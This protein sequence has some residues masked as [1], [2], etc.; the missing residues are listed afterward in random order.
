MRLALR[1]AL[2]ISSVSYDL[3]EIVGEAEKILKID[4]AIGH[5]IEDRIKTRI[6][7]TLAKVIG[8]EKEVVKIHG[9]A[10]SG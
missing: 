5:D 4:R 10:P 3:A 8:K 1:L 2:D 6:V 9:V 7:L